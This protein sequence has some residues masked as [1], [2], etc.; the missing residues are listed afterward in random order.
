[1]ARQ[2]LNASD[3]S[4]H[5][6]EERVEFDFVEPHDHQY[7]KEKVVIRPEDLSLVREQITSVYHRIR[8]HDFTGCGDEKCQWCTFVRSNFRQPNDILE[9]PSAEEN[10]D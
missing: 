3:P 1:V 5:V 8:K 2:H 6:D 9:Q 4:A 7:I 10:E